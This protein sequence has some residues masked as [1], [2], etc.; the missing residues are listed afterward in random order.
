MLSK[1][2]VLGSKK[3]QSGFSAVEVLLAVTIFGFLVTALT[4][5]LI[6]GRTASENSGHQ[7]RAQQVLDEGV[8]AVRSIRNTNFTGLTNGTYGLVSSG[9]TWALSG[10]SDVS[11]IYTRQV[12]I[13]SGSNINRK[14]VTVTVT[15][16]KA[17][18]G[19]AT[20]SINSNMEFTNYTGTLKLWTAAAT[21]NS[22]YGSVNVTNTD[23]GRRVATAGNYA[24][25]VRN[26]GTPNF[27]VINISN[28]AAPT[29]AGSLTLATMNPTAIAVS[30]N[31]AYVASGADS[32]ELQVIDI[33]NPATPVAAA[34]GALNLA[35]TGDGL[36]VFVNNGY[37]Y[38]SRASDATTNANE[39]TIINATNYAV[40]GGYNNAINMNDVWVSGNYAY[41]ATSSTT[42]EMLVINILSPTAPTLAATYNPATAIAATAVSGYGNT[43]FLS[44]TTTF[45][46]IN[47]TTPTAPARIDA[48]PLVISGNI[49]DIAVD[50]TG[51][52][53]YVGTAA[54][55]GEFQIIDIGTVSATTNAR[56]VDVTGTTSTVN[57]VAY[58]DALGV[59]IAV[60]TSDTL[61]TLIVGP[62]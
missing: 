31:R 23:D 50:S 19:G 28:P 44:M 59:A 16:T 61:E 29:L 45:D 4:G 13:T 21:S 49:T 32:N 20:A 27:A 54:T 26:T 1:A 14:L 41:L 5:V 53:A 48:T 10:S 24:Y 62:M 38:L 40:I 47:I 34:G 15:W 25:V 8:E 57:G 36:G 9:G 17:A 6:F 52:Y 58:S 11:G 56:I 12:T 39:L 42:A 18:S 3:S 43:V 7:V 37:V 60:S 46:A 22:F 55:A 30:G 35:G 33:S 51:K 2:R